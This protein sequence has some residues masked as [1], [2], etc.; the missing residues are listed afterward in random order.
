M[1]YSIAVADY[2]SFVKRLLRLVQS[3]LSIRT[4]ELE[5]RPFTDEDEQLDFRGQPM[6]STDAPSYRLSTAIRASA[7]YSAAPFETC[8]DD[9]YVPPPPPTNGQ[10]SPRAGPGAA[11][12]IAPDCEATTTTK[13]TKSKKKRKSRPVSDD[14]VEV[15]TSACNELPGWK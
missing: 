15:S 5:L 9:D 2:I 13:K 1:I 7:S 8:I 4:M 6:T 12:D 14:V 11:N 10:P 3:Y